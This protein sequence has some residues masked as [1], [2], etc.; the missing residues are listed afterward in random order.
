MIINKYRYIDWFYCPPPK[1]NHYHSMLCISIPLHLMFEWKALVSHQSLVFE[2]CVSWH[3]VKRSVWALFLPSVEC[4]HGGCGNRC[5]PSRVHGDRRGAPYKQSRPV[6]LHAH[7]WNCHLL[8]HVPQETRANPWIQEARHSV[9]I[10]ILFHFRNDV[11]D[12]FVCM[13]FILES[14]I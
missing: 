1:K 8:V 10:W 12:M 7:C 13:Y 2:Q 9:S 5:H 6:P 11:F 3:V 4:R 14:S